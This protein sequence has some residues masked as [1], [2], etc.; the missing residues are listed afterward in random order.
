MDAGEWGR[1]CGLAALWGGSFFFNAVAVAELPPLTAVCGRVTIAA[2][3]L[4]AATRWL[5]PVP[6]LARGSWPAFLVMGALNNAVPFSLIVWAQ[7]RIDSGQAAILVAATP[8]LTALLAHGVGDE[9]LAWR[10][11]AGILLGLSGVAVLVGPSAVAGL[12]GTLDAQLACLGAAASYAAAGVYGRRFRALPPVVAAAGMVTGAAAILIPVA[13]WVDRPWALRPGPAALGAVLGVAVLSTAVGYVIY[14]RLLATAGAT[15]LLL[16]TVLNPVVATLLGA[17]VLRE[18]LPA[19]AVGGM[20]LIA[21]GLAVID[22]RWLAR[23]RAIA[24]LRAQRKT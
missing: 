20:A 2:A 17:L 9:R 8:L 21:V 1:L 5:G 16:V 7:A 14:F 22:G 12:G 18:S 19:R 10:R 24:V 13:A 4:L 23:G 11:L 6:P 3:L 15:N